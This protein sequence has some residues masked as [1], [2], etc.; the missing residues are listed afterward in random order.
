MVFSMV[1]NDGLR[2]MMVHGGG[3][4]GSR[5]SMF[6]V[7]VSA[8]VTGTLAHASGIFSCSKTERS[9]AEGDILYARFSLDRAV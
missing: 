4:D 5:L 8:K 9:S 2:H 3:E 7:G 6:T 1:R